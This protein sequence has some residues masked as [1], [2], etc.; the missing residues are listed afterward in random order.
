MAAEG[1]RIMDGP[2]LFTT[3]RVFLPLAWVFGAL[4]ILITPPF[5]VPD[6]Y[7]HF[8][9]SYQVS[10]GRLTAYRVGTD[11]GGYLPRSLVELGDHFASR[12]Q[13]DPNYRLHFREVWSLRS[14]PL[15]PRDRT[16]VVFG[17]VSWHS[18]MNY[19][20]QAA[21]IAIGRSFGLT[22]LWLLYCGRGGNLL[23]WSLL[24][25]FAIRLIP[26]MDWTLLLLALTPMSLAQASS[27][28][29]DAT[30][31][32]VCFLFVAAA[33]R[34]A[35]GGAAAMTAGRAIGLTILGAAVALAKTAYIPL[36]ILFL[37]I[38]SSKFGGRRRYWLVFSL[39]IFA[40]LAT[41]VGW[42]LCT[43][44]AQSYTAPDVS[45]RLQAIY[46]LNHPIDTLHRD[47]GMLLSV[48]YLTSI[49]GTLGWADIRLWWPCAI[50]YWVALFAT[51]CIGGWPNIRVSARQRL[52]LA[53]AACGCWLLVF[54]LVYLT[55]T[56]VGGRS[57]NGLQG[58]YLIPATP[59]FL[60]MFY[61][62]PR[63]RRFNVGPFVTAFSAVFS[64]YALAVLVRRF[65]IW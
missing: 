9:R 58:R 63:P 26:I 43:Y 23:W 55:F 34:C 12:L 60:L 36:T 1:N 4:F 16:F 14:L 56:P 8:Y 18:P 45:P 30:V 31:N 10:E 57:I 19:F 32:G 5:Q 37:L 41:I 29:A 25:Y 47:V 3:R 54:T 39:F 48:P 15:Q 13:R 62:S 52:L 7:L 42:S 65:Y 35:L 53:T 61:P 46:M 28:S 38:P 20:P 33:M 50:V 2:E 51:V 21:A 27:L 17:A 49:I 59:P 11:I 64:V 44:G 24:A 40:C 22:P 6:E